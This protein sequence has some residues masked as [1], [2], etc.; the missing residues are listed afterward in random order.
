[1]K[2][3]LRGS[4][5]IKRNEAINSI[6]IIWFS[7]KNEEIVIDIKTFNNIMD[8]D[9]T[10]NK[11][12]R[13]NVNNFYFLWIKIQET[14]YKVDKYFVVIQILNKRMNEI[15]KWSKSFSYRKRNWF[16]INIRNVMLYCITFN[17]KKLSALINLAWQSNSFIRS[18]K[19]KENF[20]DNKLHILWDM[21][22]WFNIDK[23]RLLKL[24]KIELIELKLKEQ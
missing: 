24:T 23:R 22:K 8:K 19:E 5:Q 16:N 12:K 15:C 6:E 17:F 4:Q 11:I 7:K 3:N 20:Y 1:L 10:I 14:R 9:L 13:L 2:S 21:N 18:A